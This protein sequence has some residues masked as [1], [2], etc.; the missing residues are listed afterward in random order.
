MRVD[1]LDAIHL[2]S[3]GTQ[4]RLH[5][6]NRSYTAED[7]LGEHQND[8]ESIGASLSEQGDILLYGCDLASGDDGLLLV[9]V[10]ARLTS[11]DVAASDDTTGN[12]RE[13][14]DWELEMS[15]GSIEVA[16]LWEPTQEI[17]WSGTLAP[18]P[19][20]TMDVPS[21]SFI[22]E[23]FG[24]SVTFE[25]TSGVPSDAGYAPYID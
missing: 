7:L 15:F 1:P 18:T 9:D 17:A 14:G 3:H 21:E 16:T 19:T 23:D 11:A 8:L 2:I 22:N 13:G 10:F 6:G 24:F 20:V 4:G 25:N 5:L 12:Q